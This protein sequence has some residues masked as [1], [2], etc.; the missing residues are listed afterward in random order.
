MENHCINTLIIT[1]DKKFSALMCHVV[2]VVR[3]KMIPGKM[4]PGKM[5]PGK[6][7]PEK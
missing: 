1:V 4:I 5:I 6:M 3:G 7:I 2:V